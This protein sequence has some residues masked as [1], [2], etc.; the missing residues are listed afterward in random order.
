MD[1]VYRVSLRQVLTWLTRRKA[2]ARPTSCRN[3]VCGC[4]WHN[5]RPL[6][7]PRDS[8]SLSWID[9]GR[10]VQTVGDLL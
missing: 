6:V 9:V 7:S 2:R 4:V 10:R 1:V 5:R 8:L 3:M